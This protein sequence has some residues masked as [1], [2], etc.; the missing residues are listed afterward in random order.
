MYLCLCLW[1][2]ECVW[3]GASKSLVWR[4]LL[5]HRLRGRCYSLGPFFKKHLPAVCVSVFVPVFCF[6][7]CL[8]SLL[9]LCATIQRFVSLQCSLDRGPFGALRKVIGIMLVSCW[10]AGRCIHAGR[11]PRYSNR[12]DTDAVDL[13]FCAPPSFCRASCAAG[14][15][16]RAEGHRRPGNYRESRHD[17]HVKATSDKGTCRGGSVAVNIVSVLIAICRRLLCNCV[18]ASVGLIF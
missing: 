12:N 3:P 13:L 11:M 2:C 5:C 7:L 6:K 10:Q 4:S 14:G 1:L 17:S 9:G 18:V 16:H 8:V 15:G